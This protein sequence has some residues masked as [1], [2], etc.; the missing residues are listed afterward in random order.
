M[1]D[2]FKK[3]AI[4]FDNYTTT[5]SPVH[6]EFVTNFHRKV[7]KNGYIFTQ[8]SELPYCPNCKRFLPDRFVEGECPY[9]GYGVARGDQCEQCGSPTS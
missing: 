6:K 8:V 7:F 2:L 3:W 1:L 9:C 5:E 4:T